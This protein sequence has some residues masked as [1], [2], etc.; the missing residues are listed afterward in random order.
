MFKTGRSDCQPSE[1]ATEFQQYLASRAEHHP[2]DNGNGEMTVS[3]YDRSEFLHF[4]F[5][6]DF[7]LHGTTSAF[8]LLKASTSIAIFPSHLK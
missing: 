7:L 4:D 3:Y 8:S 2:D 1:A 6:V 5:F